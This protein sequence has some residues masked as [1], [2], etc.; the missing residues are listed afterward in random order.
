MHRHGIVGASRRGMV[1]LVG[2][3]AGQPLSNEHEHD[4]P[5]K[6]D[7]QLL[8]GVHGHHNEGVYFQFH[9]TSQV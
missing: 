5:G 2:P 3:Q 8:V 6:M 9:S 4:S 1:L 7:K